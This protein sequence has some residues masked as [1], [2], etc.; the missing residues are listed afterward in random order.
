MC[1][2]LSLHIETA[3]EA[4]MKAVLQWSDAVLSGISVKVHVR[5]RQQL[6]ACVQVHK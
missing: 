4:N 5:Q 3:T 6:Q 1:S 2:P